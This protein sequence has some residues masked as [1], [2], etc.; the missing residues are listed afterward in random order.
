MWIY[1]RYGKKEKKIIEWFFFM[2]V[3]LKTVGLLR[4]SCFVLPKGKC[5]DLVPIFNSL[6]KSEF[7][8]CVSFDE[9][10]KG[11]RII[12]KQ[13]GFTVA[14]FSSGKVMVYGLAEDCK[15]KFFLNLVWKSFFCKNMAKL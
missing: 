15:V 10:F 12:L 9:N 3:E 13:E 6:H 11:P 4:R 5:L 14:C 7:C 8:N 2:V 1:S